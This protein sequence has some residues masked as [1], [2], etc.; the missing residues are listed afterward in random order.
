MIVIICLIRESICIIL[1]NI[2]F[3]FNCIF[4]FCWGGRRTNS[5]H[6]H[7][8][9]TRAFDRTSY[10]LEMYLKENFVKLEL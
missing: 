1:C 9:R 7:S 4:I 2:I 3:T 6:L 8:Y 10:N 5:S